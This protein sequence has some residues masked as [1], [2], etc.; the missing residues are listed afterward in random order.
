MTGDW[1]RKPDKGSINEKTLGNKRKNRQI[2]IN[3][4]PPNPVGTEEENRSEGGAGY[5]VIAFLFRVLVAAGRLR[6]RLVLQDQTIRGQ[7]I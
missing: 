1:E 6:F 5:Y 3:E 4:K 7:A 2:E